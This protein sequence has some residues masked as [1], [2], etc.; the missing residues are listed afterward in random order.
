MH[1]STM[2]SNTV[3]ARIGEADLTQTAVAAT[4]VAE[5]EPTANGDRTLTERMTET[6]G[7][8][9]PERPT[10]LNQLG[11]EDDFVRGLALKLAS[12]VSELSTEWAAREL[13]LPI[14]LVEELFWHLKK[15]Q[16]V[17]VLGQIAPFNYRYALTSRGKEQADR[18]FQI[19]GYVGPVPVALNDYVAM[20]HWDEARRTRSTRDEVVA[21]LDTLTLDKDVVEVAALAAA[22]NRSLFLFGPPGNG[23]T[24]LGRLIHRVQ[25]GS[26]WI[27]HALAVGTSVIQLFDP[28]CHDLAPVDGIT[29]HDRRW[30]HIE[31]PFVVAGGEMTIGDLD[32]IYSPTL[33]SY[34]APPHVKANGG[35]FLI[36]DFGRQRVKPEE[37][38]NRWIIPL[39]HRTDYATLHTGQKISLPFCQMLIVATNLRVS[40]VADPAFLRRMGYRVRIDAPCETRFRQIFERYASDV[41]LEFEPALLDHLLERYRSESRELRGSEPRE[42]IE[43]CRDVCSL[44]D[45]QFSIDQETLDMA[46]LAFFGETD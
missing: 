23:K 14:Q 40:E 26:L 11:V 39:E 13:C 12:T 30:H 37:L 34:E 46:W 9:Y 45:K 35:T 20:L 44:T 5:A 2:D 27:P 43:R 21:A 41:G 31:R 8:W 29:G 42:L 17:E 15:H 38:L 3:T 1:R 16:M 4:G 33:R 22:S 6:N 32:L 36:D 7:I 28:Q 18:L 19:C 25:S 24:S 10:T